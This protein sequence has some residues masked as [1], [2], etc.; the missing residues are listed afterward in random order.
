MVQW[1]KYMWQQMIVSQP[2]DPLADLSSL[3]SC[4]RGFPGGFQL[5]SLKPQHLCSSAW[6]LSGSYRRW[7][8]SMLL[9]ETLS[10]GHSSHWWGDCNMYSTRFRRGPPWDWV[11]VAH[12]GYH[13][14]STLF[15]F[16][17]ACLSPY[18]LTPASWDQVP[19]KAPHP[20]AWL[21]ACC[22]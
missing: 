18:S 16:L 12:I 4:R 11:P 6:G 22:V 19:N 13:S 2:Q 17:P 1:I 5:P 7:G 14:M 3:G 10:L 20:S 8:G 15:G 21:H 9:G